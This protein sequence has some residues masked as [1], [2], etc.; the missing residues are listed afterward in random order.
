ML[1]MAY[2]QEVTETYFLRVSSVPNILFIPGTGS[3]DAGTLVRLDEVPEKWNEYSFV[4]WK[5]NGVWTLG[6]TLSI[7]MDRSYDVE[8]VFEKTNQGNVL[9]DVIPRIAEITV[10][11]E[12]FL[13]S[14]LPVSLEWEIGTEHTLRAPD[15]V[16]DN[17]STRYKFDSW[18]D[19]N[20]EQERTVT[21]DANDDSAE[22]IALYR[23]QH[24]LKPISEI[25]QVVGGGWQNEG[26]TSIFGVESEI[27]LDEKDDSARYVFNS[28]N[29]GDYPKKSENQLDIESSTTVTASWDKEYKLD[30]LTDVPDYDL[31]GTGWYLAGKKITLIAE[32]SLE[33]DDSKI[34]Y[35]FDRWV[36]KGPNPMIIPNAQSP[37]TT[38]TLDS[39]YVIEAQYKKSYQVDVWTP[40]SRATGAGF[41]DEGSTAEI[42]IAQ[43]ELI[44]KP[45]K[46]K[47][48]FNDWNTHG[49]PTINFGESGGGSST[50]NLLIQ[51]DEPLTINA[52]WK[53][54]FYLNVMSSEG[55]ATG[56]GWYD[57]GKFIPISVKE[58][59]VPKDF[60]TSY[61]FK[62][63]SG[64]YDDPDP[65][66]MIKIE[67]PMLIV[68]EWE[69]DTTTGILNILLIGGAG[70]VG[71]VVFIK[72]RKNKLLTMFKKQ[73]N[74]LE[75][76]QNPFEKYEEKAVDYEYHS[77]MQKAK[78]K[79][80]MD[81]LL[82]KHN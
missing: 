23:L 22:F 36:S 82:G 52:N 33:S 29:S 54:Q 79:A 11:G 75:Y 43:S 30:I 20:S 17:P 51:V 32:E 63:W 41:Y 81:W 16:K 69:E 5:V 60:W 64:D 39:P 28:W 74:P 19:N 77:P 37:F 21:V 7:R 53:T 61:A 59:K 42:R 70:A 56:T 34:K 45:G 27:V 66:A 67:E 18:K 12:I 13:P 48:I 46:E 78:K 10:D 25:G 72:T 76:E 2:A 62:G 65:R 26:G 8:A 3:Y 40:Y 71:V 35:V 80:L 50:Q 6:D 55:G 24:F 68:A 31:F 15:V 4:G 58:T 57:I 44:V 1:E 49:A 38:I 9:I 14:E 47:K 73:Q